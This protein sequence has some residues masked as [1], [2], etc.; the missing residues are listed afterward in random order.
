MITRW[1]GHLR[2]AYREFAILNPARHGAALAFYGAFALVPIL[3]VSY[4]LTRTLLAERGLLQLA[5]M[6]AQFAELL[7][8]AAALAIQTQVAEA[9]ARTQNGSTLVTIV[10]VLAL[11]YTASGAFAQLKYSLNTIWGV[12]HD[13]QLR[14]GAMVVTR[15][16][17]MALVFGVGLLLVVAVVASVVLAS[18]S[19]LLGLTGTIPVLNL[20]LS[21]VL[22]TLLFTLLYKILPDARVSWVS[23][24]RSAALAALAV[25]IGLALVNLYF[26]YVR[27]NTALS[28]AGGLAV[29]LISL[30]Y[31]AQIFLF[32]AVVSRRLDLRA[33][34]IPPPS[35][36]AKTPPVK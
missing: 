10:G 22:V 12:P 30:N 13:T 29:I 25:A 6:Q 26:R 16:L 34:A 14:T 33:A 7:G 3:A 2:D 31:G 19:G 21:F 5:D 24:G 28:V 17:G 18:L 9:T 4:Q 32:G 8:P 35:L 15:L 36:A 1:L 11:L 20:L 23:A 27:L